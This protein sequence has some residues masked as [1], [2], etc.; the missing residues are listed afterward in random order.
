MSRASERAWN[1]FVLLSDPSALEIG[2]DKRAAALASLF[3]SGAN[4]GGLNSFLTASF[5]YDAGEVQAA[6]SSI[7]ALKAAHQL[8]E[9]LGRLGSPLSPATQD[10]RWAELDRCW[11]EELD[12]YDVLSEEADDELMQA[13]AQHVSANEAYYLELGG[14]A[15]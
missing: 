11:A 13:L 10:L 8:G 3:L 14:P 2:N 15:D 9:V 4:N 7:G 5:E 12:Q 6:L 1:N